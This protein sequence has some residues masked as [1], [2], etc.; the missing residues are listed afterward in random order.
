MLFLG[1]RRLA[2]LPDPL[3]LIGGRRQ[4]VSCCP[5]PAENL[6]QTSLPAVTGSA[7]C[8]S[9][10]LPTLKYPWEGSRKMM[11]WSVATPKQE[12]DAALSGAEIW[13]RCRSQGRRVEAEERLRSKQ[14]SSGVAS[15]RLVSRPHRR[16]AAGLG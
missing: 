7:V 5:S 4:I 15:C 10:C 2:A 1:C 6:E 16:Q 14:L 12:D 9:S 3:A 11:Q 8:T 13:E